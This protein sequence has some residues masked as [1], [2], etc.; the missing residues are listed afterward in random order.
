MFETFGEVLEFV[1]NL[2]DGLGYLGWIAFA[3]GRRRPP[4]ALTKALAFRPFN[5]QWSAWWLAW[6]RET[7]I[8]RV[9]SV[10]A[11]G[12]FPVIMA[13][14]ILDEVMG[15]PDLMIG[16]AGLCMIPVAGCVCIHFADAVGKRLRKQPA[17]DILIRVGRGRY[18]E[19][20]YDDD[21]HGQL[22]L[23]R[24]C[25]RRQDGD[26]GSI[27]TLSLPWLQQEVSGWH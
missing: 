8:R 20:H 27:P 25:P 7:L 3:V 9:T 11:L 5:R 1:V 10:S 21:H 14:A 13:V 18:G 15:L 26:T 6:K 22:P 4:E 19:I 23:L 17:V 2:L 12:A 16:V 24:W